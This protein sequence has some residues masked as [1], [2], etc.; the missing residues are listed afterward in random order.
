MPNP[1][2][3][4]ARARSRKWALQEEFVTGYYVEATTL[5]CKLRLEHPGQIVR[6]TTFQQGK[7]GNTST[8]YAIRRYKKGA[9]P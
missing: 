5:Q 1:N 4:V 6:I 3:T 8:R 9:S 2:T 7:R